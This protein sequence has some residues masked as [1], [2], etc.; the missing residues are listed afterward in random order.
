MSFKNINK[1]GRN[2]VARAIARGW[3]PGLRVRDF[4]TRKDKILKAGF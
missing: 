1:S 4:L 3:R 2:K